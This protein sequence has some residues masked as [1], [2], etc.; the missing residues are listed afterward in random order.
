LDSSF[1]SA[2][3][4]QFAETMK[5]LPTKLTAKIPA[6]H[7]RGD[8]DDQQDEQSE[9]SEIDH[10]CHVN[11]N[12]DVTS[13]HQ[14]ERVLLEKIEFLT[15]KLEEAT[16]GKARATK[17]K[18][19][20]TGLQIPI[21]SSTRATAQTNQDVESVNRYQDCVD[22]DDDD[23]VI[24]ATAALSKPHQKSTDTTRRSASNFSFNTVCTPTEPAPKK[25]STKRKSLNMFD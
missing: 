23:E 21:R 25:R 12:L 15:Q 4:E 14:R 8:S 1:D 11:Q 17:N 19:S 9:E 24:R 7:K 18:T 13:S 20:H 22:F 3:E 16:K 6:L 10:P 5:D 2:F